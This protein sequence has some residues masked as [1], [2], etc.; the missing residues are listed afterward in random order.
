MRLS[1][2]CGPAATIDRLLSLRNLHG[3]IDLLLVRIKNAISPHM[4]WLDFL[5]LPVSNLSPAK[6]NLPQGH[7]FSLARHA[8]RDFRSPL[9]FSKSDI[10][11]FPGLPL[12]A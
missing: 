1:P 11:P 9:F 2:R 8:K 3:S 12:V 6:R 7:T 4:I 5:N 10:S